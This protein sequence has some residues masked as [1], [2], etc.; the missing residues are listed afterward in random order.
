MPTLL[1]ACLEPAA[2]AGQS[3]VLLALNP[4]PLW[5][6]HSLSALLTH[7]TLCCVISH[8]H[9]HHQCPHPSP[10]S[11]QLCSASPPPSLIQEC[12]QHHGTPHH[13]CPS[14]SPFPVSISKH[15]VDPSGL[16][17]LLCGNARV[18][19]G[20]DSYSLSF[21]PQPEQADLETKQ[22]AFI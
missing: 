21:S 9:Q 5:V 17:R 18:S 14:H 7:E 20:L 6:P 3:T 11:T 19:G 13:Q 1:Q 22:V 8:P 12:S 10:N 4:N 15:M 2:A 16:L